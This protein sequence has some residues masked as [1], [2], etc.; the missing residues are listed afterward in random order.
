MAIN[1]YFP[2]LTTWQRLARRGLLLLGPALLPVVASAQATLSPMQAY[3]SGVSSPYGVVVADMNNDGVPDVVTVSGSNGNVGILPGSATVRG[4]FGTARLYATGMPNGSILLRTGDLN[5]DGLPDVL[6]SSSTTASVGV[7]LN[8]PTAPGTLQAPVAYTTTAVGTDVRGVALGDVN[9]DGNLDVVINSF[10]ASR[11]GV[12]LGSPTALG[13]LQP[14]VTYPTGGAQLTSVALADMNGDG[15]LDVVAIDYSTSKV[16]VLANQVAN[17][18]TFGAAV[19]YTSGGRACFGLVVGDVNADNRPDVVVANLESYNISILLNSATTPGTLLPASVYSSGGVS[20]I[21]VDLGDLNADGRPDIVT[22]NFGSD[23]LGVLLNLATAPGTFG[24][25]TTYSTGSISAPRGVAVRD[26]SNDGRNDVVVANY[27]NSTVGVLLNGNTVAAPA[28]TAI[29]PASGPVGTSITLTGTNLSGATAVSFNGTLATTFAVVNATTITATVPTGASTGS[30]TI[31]TSGGISNGLLFS[32]VLPTTATPTLTTPTNGNTL[33]GLPTY[34]GTA[35]AG[36]LVTVYIVPNGGTAQAVGTT[37]AGSGG[38]FTLTPSTALTSGTYSAYVTAQSSGQAVSAN[39]NTS[40][41]TVDATPPTVTSLTTT[42]SNPTTTVPI[43]F[44]VTFSEAVFGFG[45]SGLSVSNGTVVSGPSGSGTTYTFGVAPASSG[46]VVVSI[47]AGAVQDAVGNLNPASG[48]LSVNY[49]SVTTWRSPGSN[50]WFDA[51]NWTAGVPTTTVDALIPGTATAMPVI[52]TGSAST[53]TL[54]IGT[55]ATLTQI[56][57]NLDVRGDWVNNGTYATGNNISGGTVILG[58]V[59]TPNGPNILGSSPTRFWNLTVQSNGALLGTAA[60]ASVQR[61]LQLNGPLASQNNPLTLESDATGTAL[62]VNNG[63][64]GVISGPATFQRYLSPST[65]AGLG[66]R[67]LAAPVSNATVGSLATATFTPVVNAAYNTSTAPGTVTPFPT[68]YGYD[69]ARL[70]TTT[71]NLAA[72]DKGW[73][74][75]AASSSTLSPGQG[76][77]VNLAAGQ[78]VSFTG[79]QN[80]AATQPLTQL[81]ARNASGTADAASAG[82]A[83]VGNPFPSPLD[84][85]LVDAADR[86][87]LDAAIYVFES[88]S[89]YG[90]TYRASLNGVGGNANSGSSVLAMGQGFFVRVSDGQASGTLNFRNTQR[91]TSYQNPGLLR[92]A[93][94]RPLVQLSLQGAGSALADEAYVYVEPGATSSFEADYDAVKL[95]NP[96]GLNLSIGSGLRQLAIDGRAALTAATVLPLAVGVPAA[97]TYTLRA[98]ALANL[99]VGLTAYLRDAQTGQVIALGTGTTYSFGVTAAQA[100]T[101]LTGRFA[102]AFGTPSLLAA[103]PTLSAELVS[104][105]PN[106]AHGS[107]AVVVPGVAGAREVQAELLNVLGQVVHRQAAALPASG[108][109]LSVAPGA[110][111]TGVYVLRLTAGAATLTQR[112]VLR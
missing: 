4:T 51:S 71:S 17:P 86:A 16:F 23:N 91:L 36:S 19:G 80:N 13:T 10:Q 61:V 111:A 45:T 50:D 76:Y 103:V 29:S 105:Y 100:Q 53:R 92:P 28:L 27:M 74:S 37:T 1:F 12:L 56:G 34:R 85:A 81:L 18:G 63:P 3:P 11:V 30:V 97:G 57:G 102:V 70:A 78:A 21:E 9:G 109:T 112:V 95:P 33:N 14:I 8:T 42:A 96:S 5:K 58:Q 46:A 49:T 99:P 64:A 15:G 73:V 44:T 25:A 75:P 101:L 108:T 94:P 54:T 38:T 6:V 68:V 67:H 87:G 72:F 41:F 47:R 24:A 90:G 66:Y 106:P 26:V 7:L 39:S 79:S 82:W 83:L 35:P 93:A 20:T 84:Y 22:S 40:T 77:T 88:S 98:A 110:L 31:T 59:A 107:F 43:R 52:S 62:V 65:N 89:Q 104:V 48:T 2:T 32:V 55:G 69:Q 60:G